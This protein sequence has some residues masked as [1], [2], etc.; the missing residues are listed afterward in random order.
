MFRFALGKS[1]RG[2]II[3][4]FIFLGFANNCGLR[5]SQQEIDRRGLEE[6]YLSLGQTRCLDSIDART[7]L[8]TRIRDAR[9]LVGLHALPRDRPALVA[10]GALGLEGAG[11]ADLVQELMVRLSLPQLR[12]H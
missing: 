11:R 2:S 9:K 1:K 4:I 12:L 5:K 10:S 6:C 7:V 3:S 8:R